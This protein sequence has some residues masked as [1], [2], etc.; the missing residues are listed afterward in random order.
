MLRC[1]VGLTIVVLLSGCQLGGAAGPGNRPPTATIDAPGIGP[2]GSSIPF[3]AVSSDPDGDALT[4]AWSFGDGAKLVTSDQ[5]VDHV[6]RNNGSYVTTLIVS[7]SHGAADTTSTP[8][9]IANVEPQITVL[10]FPDSVVAGEPFEIEIQYH[11]PGLD[12]TVYADLW[13]G[14]VGSGS[15]GGSSLLGPGTVV[16][17]AYEAGQYAFSVIA[18][19]NDWAITERRGD[20][21]LVVLPRSSSETIA[22]A[23]R[24]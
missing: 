14:R 1:A 15:G 24:R 8:L 22:R 18:R 13:R 9:T 3:N 5:R 16:Q 19:D 2:E 20:H 12:D 17:M 4:F 6:Y 7:D 23:S 11:D 21:Y 10:R